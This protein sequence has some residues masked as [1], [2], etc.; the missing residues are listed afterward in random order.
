MSSK[1]AGYREQHPFTSPVG[2][3]AA[4]QFGLYDLG[5]NSL[6][7]CDDWYDGSQD[8]RVLRGGSW[9]F[10]HRDFLLSSCRRDS[11]PD[12]RSYRIGFRVVLV[13]ESER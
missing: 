6:E 5:G 2:S 4:N 9:P 10:G 3:Y 1:I 13:A 11:T 8:S 12:R 7:W